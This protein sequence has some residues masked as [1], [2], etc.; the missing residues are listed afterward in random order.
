MAS[1]SSSS[2]SSS[3]RP[4]PSAHQDTTTATADDVV[5]DQEPA[6]DMVGNGGSE[7]ETR[8]MESAADDVAETGAASAAANAEVGAA[9]APPELNRRRSFLPP[10]HVLDLTTENNNNSNRKT[11][12]DEGGDKEREIDEILE[13]DVVVTESACRGKRKDG[14]ETIATNTTPNLCHNSSMEPSASKMMNMA[15]E[16]AKNNNPVLLQQQRSSGLVGAIRVHPIGRRR[17]R[18]IRPRERGVG[19][20]SG[21]I[22]QPLHHQ[23][24]QVNFENTLTLTPQESQ[25]GIVTVVTEAEKVNL[26]DAVVVFPPQHGGR[27]KKQILICIL[28]GVLFMAVAIVALSV[29]LSL[30]SSTHLRPS[31]NGDGNNDTPTTSGHSAAAT[32]AITNLPP[33]LEVIRQRGSLSCFHY[34]I[35]LGYEFVSSGLSR[36]TSALTSPFLLLVLTVSPIFLRNCS[37]CRMIAAAI[38]GD[39]NRFESPSHDAIPYVT[40]YDYIANGTVDLAV[41]AYTMSRDFVIN[42][43]YARLKPASP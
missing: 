12:D 6:V 22:S 16:T 40:V 36:A 7:E 14:D 21:T 25:G 20:E 13:K 9:S 23:R 4:Y 35:G 43:S 17:N 19:V 32:T 5:H 34:N 41:H 37:Q 38:F 24:Q 30:S 1:S 2:S 33:T 31:K 3:S 11:D 27:N 18:Y 42:V 39:P 8:R 10:Q 26:Q 28:C 15:S 29:L